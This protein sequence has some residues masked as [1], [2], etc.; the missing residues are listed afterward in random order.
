MARKKGSSEEVKRPVV[1]AACCGQCAK[2]YDFCYPRRSDGAAVSCRCPD[3]PRYL[4]LCATPACGAFK[5]RGSGVRIRVTPLPECEPPSEK[6]VPLFRPGEAEPWKCVPA[7][8]IP[9]GGISWTGEPALN[10]KSEPV[11][12]V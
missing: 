3:D 4:R 11:K 2:A 1:P 7:E 5:R 12:P 10:V 6:C 8:E 9:I